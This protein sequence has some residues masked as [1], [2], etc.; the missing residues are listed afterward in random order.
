[1]RG[2]AF[3]DLSAAQVREGFLD[4]DLVARQMDK[5]Q[6]GFFARFGGFTSTT[7]RR[8]IRSRR[9]PNGKPS[10]AG[11]AP[12]NRSGLLKRNTFF[13][14]DPVT[15][16]LVV[17]PAALPGKRPE[18][19]R[20]LEEGGTVRRK[21]GRRPRRGEPDTRTEQSVRVEARPYVGPAFEKAQARID[22]FWRQAAGLS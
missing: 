6:R 8:S 2:R 16:N 19:L 13:S 7:I 12:V 18:T 5:V 17:G 22:D 3:S 20:V 11:K 14:I 10:A 4:R 9:G 1:M 21:V 15:Q